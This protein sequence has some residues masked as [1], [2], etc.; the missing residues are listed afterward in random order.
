MNFLEYHLKFYSEKKKVDLKQTVSGHLPGVAWTTGFL[1]H[2]L[3]GTLTWK[4]RWN[5][6]YT[7]ILV[8]SSPTVFEYG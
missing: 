4:N 2:G 5:P 7:E 3:Q 8:S 6:D 1:L